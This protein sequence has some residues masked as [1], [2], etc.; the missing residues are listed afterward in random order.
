[1]GTH[2]AEIHFT[3]D[4]GVVQ[5]EM[6]GVSLNAEGTCFYGMQVHP[7]RTHQSTVVA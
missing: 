2:Q 7:L 1:M 5:V 6:F 4:T 3:E